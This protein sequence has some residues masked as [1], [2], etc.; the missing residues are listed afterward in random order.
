MPL[1]PAAG[2][3]RL[4]RPHRRLH[5]WRYR[6][7][8]LVAGEEVADLLEDAAV[9]VPALPGAGR[10]APVL[11]LAREPCELVELMGGEL[12]RARQPAGVVGARPHPPAEFTREDAAPLLQRALR[13]GVAAAD[14]GGQ[15]AGGRSQLGCETLCG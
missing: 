10:L 7:L 3:V 4:G 2:H 6:R 1:A 15:R 5:R 9:V 14:L 11:L 12:H 8:L 13:V